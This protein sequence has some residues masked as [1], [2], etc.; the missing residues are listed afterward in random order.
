M[1]QKERNILIELL[2]ERIPSSRHSERSAESN[3]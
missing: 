3:D 1:T 2:N